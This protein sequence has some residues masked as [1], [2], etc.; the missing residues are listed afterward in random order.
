[1]YIIELFAIVFSF[2]VKNNNNIV[3]PR[4]HNMR[5]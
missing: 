3:C 2:N 4:L 5:L 1:M